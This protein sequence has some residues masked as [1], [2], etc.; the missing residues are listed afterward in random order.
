M[1]DVKMSAFC[2]PFEYIKQQMSKILTHGHITGIA[3]LKGQF[4]S[5]LLGRHSQDLWVTNFLVHCV[6]KS[7]FLDHRCVLVPLI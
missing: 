3:S 6:L 2:S 1:T 4:G 7:N 5:N